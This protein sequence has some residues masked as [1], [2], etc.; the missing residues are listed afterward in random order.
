L[1]FII[2]TKIYLK[3]IKQNN[4][5]IE[6]LKNKHKDEWLAI[7]VTKKKEGLPIEGEIVYHNKDRKQL[8]E[9]TREIDDLMIM[10]AGKIVKEGY[11]YVL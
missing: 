2:K 7:K 4:M 5:K 9:K 1:K 8:H 10:Y 11:A 6:E 3:N